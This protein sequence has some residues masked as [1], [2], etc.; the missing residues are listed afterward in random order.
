M[1]E[2]EEIDWELSWTLCP[3]CEHYVVIVR[4][5]KDFDEDAASEWMVYPKGSTRPS[6]PA[7]VPDEFAA[8]YREAAIVLTD[9]PKASAALSRRCLQHLLRE[10]AGVKK[11][12]LSKEIQEVIDSRDLPTHLSEAIDAVR[13][14]GNFAA[15]PLKSQSTG[16]VVDV[17]PGEAE[18]NLDVLDELFDHYFVQPARFEAQKAQLNAKLADLGKPAMKSG[19]S[20]KDAED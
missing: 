8:D 19:A 17:E 5:V 13:N 3:A 7:S 1:G 9:S 4:A 10:K 18:W 15:H 2:V 11:A 12:D 20:K 16:E 14:H 6:L